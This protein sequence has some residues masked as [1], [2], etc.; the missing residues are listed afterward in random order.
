MF[1]PAFWRTCQEPKYGVSFGWAFTITTSYTAN[2]SNGGRLSTGCALA[3][4]LQFRV[5]RAR[6]RFPLARLRAGALGNHKSFDERLGTEEG[7]SGVSVACR[8][9]KRSALRG[10][11]SIRSGDR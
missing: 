11:R 9:L 7:Y 6:R 2:D 3:L 5:V 4:G 10:R 8:S 1:G